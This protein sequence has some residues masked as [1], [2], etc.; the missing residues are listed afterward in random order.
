VNLVDGRP[1]S[2]RSAINK[3]LGA[4]WNTGVFERSIR[5]CRFGCEGCARRVH[6]RCRWAENSHEVDSSRSSVGSWKHS[7]TVENYF[8]ILKRGVYGVYHHVSEAH[9]SRYLSEFDFRYSTHRISDVERA[10]LMLKA[11]TGKRLTY[12]PL[13]EGAHA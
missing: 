6:G 10:D 2:Q 9:L 8:S 13:G 7:N 5:G 12:R 3:G 11:T 1:L 4:V